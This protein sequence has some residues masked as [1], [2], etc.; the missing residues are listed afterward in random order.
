MGGDNG[1]LCYGEGRHVGH[2]HFTAR[3]IRPA[4]SFGSGLGYGDVRLDDARLEDQDGSGPRIAVMVS[5]QAPRDTLALVQAYRDD[6]ALAG[7]A[8]TPVAAG[9]TAQLTIDIHPSALR[10]WTH[11]GWSRLQPRLHIGLCAEDRTFTINPSR[12]MAGD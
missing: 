4:F 8:R 1:R 6:G 7:F 12:A 10:Q 3:G 2:R 5:N 9:A 11:E